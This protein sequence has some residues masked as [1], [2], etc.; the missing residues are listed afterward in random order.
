MY[1]SIVVT[2]AF[3][4]VAA[5]AEDPKKTA[6]HKS[7]D[8]TRVLF[9]GKTLGD[10]KVVDFYKHGDVKVADGVMKLEP[11]GPMTGVVWKGAKLPTKNY[12]VTW[13]ARRTEGRDF[14]CALTFQV[15]ED[16]CTFVPAG[17]GGNITGLS[18]INGSD[19]SENE[20]QKY[21]EFENDKWYKFKLRVDDA[22]IRAWVDDEEVVD[23]AY[24]DVKLSVRIEVNQNRPLG[25]ATYRS[26]AEIRNV[27]LREL[28]PTK[29]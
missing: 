18:S 16:P 9:D 7:D 25:F 14:F 19:A 1:R 15:G 20:T 4:S 22:K 27:K 24:A 29:P 17:W 3:G 11:G 6:S 21:V 23:F 28:A 2:L 10:F 26:R 12:E 5:L 13:E 8:K